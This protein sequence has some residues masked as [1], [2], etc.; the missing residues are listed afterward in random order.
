MLSCEESGI[1]TAPSEPA[2]SPTWESCARSLVFSWGRWSTRYLPLFS[3]HTVAAASAGALQPSGCRS[4]EF[5]GSQW[6]FL[7]LPRL[8][9]KQQQQQIVLLLQQIVP[10]LPGVEPFTVSGVAHKPLLQPETLARA[11]HGTWG[12]VGEISGSEKGTEP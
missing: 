4:W 11:G 12:G 10:L 6:T 7:V 5:S 8:S 2:A 1:L 3:S 9:T